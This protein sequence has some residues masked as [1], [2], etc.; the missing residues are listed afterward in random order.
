MQEIKVTSITKSDFRNIL[1]VLTKE[2]TFCHSKGE[3]ERGFSLGYIPDDLKEIPIPGVQPKEGN[4]MYIDYP[5]RYPVCIEIALPCDNI[6]E[7]LFQ[8]KSVLESILENRKEFQV[9]KYLKIEDLY[10]YK[11]T[12]CTN[13]DIIIYVES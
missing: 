8:V 2:Y 6:H 10:V 7:L 5:M 9:S 4:C 12:N 13:G 11:F 3:L 1:K